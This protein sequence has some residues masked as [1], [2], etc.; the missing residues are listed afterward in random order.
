MSKLYVF[1]FLGTRENDRESNGQPITIRIVM[2]KDDENDTSVREIIEEFY[3]ITEQLPHIYAYLNVEAKLQRNDIAFLAFDNERL[4]H[5]LT[6]LEDLDLNKSLIGADVKDYV[7]LSL[8]PK[9]SN[10]CLSDFK[11]DL[12]IPS[13]ESDNADGVFYSGKKMKSK[14]VKHKKKTKMLNFFF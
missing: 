9:Q 1:T 2:Q 12:H 11:L 6:K 7:N 14:Q 10:K 3:Q 5:N 4:S 8:H 13:K